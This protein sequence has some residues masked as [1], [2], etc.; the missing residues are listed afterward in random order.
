MI[1]YQHANLESIWKIAPELNYPRS[2]LGFGLMLGLV[3]GLGAI[4]LGGNC[5]RTNLE[6]K[7]K[8]M[9]NL[10]GKIY[11]FIITTYKSFK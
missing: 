4:F 10:F 2:G 9:A 5:S 3:L 1:S 11:L 7:R 6:S 8:W